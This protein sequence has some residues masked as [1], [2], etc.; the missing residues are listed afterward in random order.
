MKYR[1]LHF[2]VSEEVHQ[3]LDSIAEEE[4]TTMTEVMK[5]AV[6]LLKWQRDLKNEGGEIIVIRNGKE[7]TVEFF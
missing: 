2:N 6:S 3:V 7:Y 4:G 5:R 1:R